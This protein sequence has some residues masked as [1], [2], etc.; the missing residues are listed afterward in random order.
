MKNRNWLLAILSLGLL[1][2]LLFS[3]ND[4]T[5]D[6]EPVD[7]G[8]D[9]G[10]GAPA[11]GG[12]QQPCCTGNTCTAA[13]VDPVAGPTGCFCQEPCTASPCTA[14]TLQGSCT[15]LFGSL[16]APACFNP[17]DFPMPVVANDCTLGATCTTDSGVAEGTCAA[18]MDPVN[19]VLVNRCIAGCT[20]TASTCPTGAICSPATDATS[21]V[22]FTNSHCA[23]PLVAQ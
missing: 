3:C 16:P 22:D 12:S 14:G 8:S 6:E 20:P 23:A 5:D 7:T 10:S 15:T 17:T 4:E 1:G 18:V 2:M 13:G 19:M 21:T 9:T 11:C